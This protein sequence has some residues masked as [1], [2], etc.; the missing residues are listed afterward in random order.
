MMKIWVEPKGTQFQGHVEL[1]NGKE[2]ITSKRK[3]AALAAKDAYTT[4]GEYLIPVLTS[5]TVCTVASED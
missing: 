3:T 2:Y 4:A 1:A 5:S